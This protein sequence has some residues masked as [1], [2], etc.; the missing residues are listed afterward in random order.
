MTKMKGQCTKSINVAIDS[1]FFDCRTQARKFLSP[2]VLD[3]IQIK[4]TIPTTQMYA[5][6]TTQ[7]LLSYSSHKTH[8]SSSNNS[9]IV[10]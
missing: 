7:T 5:Q 9:Y 6:I 1:V 3:D 10:L 2:L 4:N 8:T